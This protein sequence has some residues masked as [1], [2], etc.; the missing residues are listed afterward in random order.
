ME[1]CHRA[2]SFDTTLNRPI[3]TQRVDNAAL[4]IS[5]DL[6][7]YIAEEYSSSFR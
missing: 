3:L 2:F 4:Q 6:L 5:S 1:A 7:T